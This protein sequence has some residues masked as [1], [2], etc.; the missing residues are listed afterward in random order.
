MLKLVILIVKTTILL[1]TQE[2]AAEAYD[3]A[4]IKF[5]GM[6]AVTNFGISKY[7]VERICASTHLLRGDLVKQSP[8]ISSDAATSSENLPVLFKNSDD[9]EFN[10]EHPYACYYPDV[11]KYNIGES[12]ANANWMVP[13]WPFML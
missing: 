9:K 6:N 3:I 4:A 5:R 7:D 2:E 13:A 8:T 1:G 10:G 12:N 11:L